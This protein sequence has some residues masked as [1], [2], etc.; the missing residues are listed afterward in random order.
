LISVLDGGAG[1][2][3]AW[4]FHPL[5]LLFIASGSLLISRTLRIPK[6]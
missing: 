2:L 6:L 3:G 5:S 1:N 4:R